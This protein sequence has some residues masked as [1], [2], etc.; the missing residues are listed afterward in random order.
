MMVVVVM[1]VMVIYMCMG[2]CMCMYLRL[3]LSLSLSIAK[4]EL[5]IGIPLPFAHSCSA[6]F[7]HANVSNFPKVV[8][9]PNL[10]HTKKTLA[11]YNC[12]QFPSAI[13]IIPWTWGASGLSCPRL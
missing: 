3:P 6:M 1:M 2:M 10:P 7:L 12:L 9:S 8:T 13:F 11:S 5:I 4:A